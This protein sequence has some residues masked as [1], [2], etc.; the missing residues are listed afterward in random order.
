MA[1]KN[2][3]E[4]SERS[5]RTI[6][7]SAYVSNMY[8]PRGSAKELS[9][10][11]ITFFIPWLALL[12][13]IL[14][15]VVRGRSRK[16]AL[17]L[18]KKEDIMGVQGSKAFAD[19]C[20][21]KRS[22]SSSSSTSTQSHSEGCPIKANVSSSDGLPSA[23]SS[24][25]SSST[26]SPS[27]SKY[28]NP[29]QYNVYSVRIDPSNQMPASAAGTNIP[30]ANQRT[31]LS[32]ERVTSNIPKGGTDDSTWVYPSP[33]MFWNAL[34][35]KGKTEGASE[36][37]MD[38]VIAVH[39]NMNETTWIQVLAW[40]Q[41]HS[42]LGPGREPKLLRFLGKPND[43][44]PKARIKMLFGHNAPF[45]RHDWVVDRGGKEIRYVIDYYHDEGMVKNDKHP[46]HLQDLT[47]M[48]SIKVD[49]RPALDS[50]SA[51]S[52]RI[53]F[54]PL[55][56]GLAKYGLFSNFIQRKYVPGLLRYNPP[57]FFPASK[58][59][60]AERVKMS[61]LSRKWQEIKIKC[62]A[63]KARLSACSSDEECSAASIALQRCT[64]SVAC[65]SIVAEFDASIRATPI[66]ETKLELS[67]EAM[68]KCLELFELESRAAKEDN[69][70]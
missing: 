45:D 16:R 67:Y 13:L 30:Q 23:G 64:A 44:S 32:T 58:T 41:L 38:A 56:Q 70:F 47:S 1:K 31:Q 35:R 21:I 15:A 19:G 5:R 26:V 57:P 17:Y 55:L 14:T 12:E 6:S 8:V 18:I 52:D 63:D 36:E 43:L 66:D 61:S 27:V 51:I 11:E 62:E 3:K 46:Q 20:P 28:K 25:G 4:G 34:V 22:S 65:P 48:K 54:M 39:N 53:I 9:C 60:E 10:L 40:E 29:N 68:I 49:V 7:R 24:S 33:Q 37:D 50:I 42:V 69:K 59:L 2:K